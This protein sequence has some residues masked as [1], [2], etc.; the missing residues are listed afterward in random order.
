MKTS[1][2]FMLAI[3]AVL[4]LGSCSTQR[5]L[6]KRHYNKGYY[7]SNRSSQ[8]TVS[9]QQREPNRKIVKNTPAEVRVSP[10]VVAHEEVAQ[11]TPQAAATNTYKK[12][13]PAASRKKVLLQQ[14]VTGQLYKQNAIVNKH[15]EIN[16]LPAAADRDS[17]SLFWVVILIIIILWAVGFFAGWGSGGLINLLLVVA[18]ILLI[19]WLLR[20]I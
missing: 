4:L 10:A 3:A 14:V 18:L 15:A 9:T 19:L 11:N 20:I 17:L 16:K 8:P 13:Q 7:L 6:L 5:T 12:A 2:T 1:I